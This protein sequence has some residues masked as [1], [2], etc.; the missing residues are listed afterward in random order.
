MILFL[1]NLV[2]FPVE[3]LQ[4]SVERFKKDLEAEKEKNKDLL[5]RYNNQTKTVE[6]M[7]IE[8]NLCKHEHSHDKK[9]IDNLK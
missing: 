6:N 8:I 2:I 5:S 1:Y 3:S 9:K 7:R 4:S